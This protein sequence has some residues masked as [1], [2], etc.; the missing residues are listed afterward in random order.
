V[1]GNYDKA[2]GVRGDTVQAMFD[3]VFVTYL[4]EGEVG[5]RL[6]ELNK[7]SWRVCNSTC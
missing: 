6:A 7:R 1:L 3:E 5:D 2:E 4:S